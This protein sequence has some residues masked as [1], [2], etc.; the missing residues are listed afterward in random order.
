[1]GD[2]EDDGD[3]HIGVEPEELPLVEGQ[4]CPVCGL[5]LTAQWLSREALY[6]ESDG[7]DHQIPHTL[8][9]PSA[10]WAHRAV[11]AGARKSLAGER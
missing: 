6:G 8:K 2:L 7:I 10:R 11:E 1:V 5:P 9:P 4:A 3:D